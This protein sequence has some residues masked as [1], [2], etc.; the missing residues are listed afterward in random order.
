MK[1]HTRATPLRRPAFAVEVHAARAAHSSVFRIHLGRERSPTS[2]QT[3]G[4]VPVYV[5]GPVDRMT[6]PV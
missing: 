1:K 6:P 3:N 5:A 4:P 2:T